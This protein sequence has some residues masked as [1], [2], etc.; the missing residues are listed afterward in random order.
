M[1]SCVCFV[2]IPQAATV[3]LLCLLRHS[4]Y[5][6]Q[7]QCWVS[8]TVRQCWRDPE[9]KFKPHVSTKCLSTK[10]W[11]FRWKRERER[12]TSEKERMEFGGGDKLSML[13]Q[14]RWMYIRL[15]SP[16]LMLSVSVE[17]RTAQHYNTSARAHASSPLP[18]FPLSLFPSFTNSFPC[19]PPFIGRARSQLWPHS[20]HCTKTDSERENRTNIWIPVNKNDVHSISYHSPSPYLSLTP[21][22]P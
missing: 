6:S 13:M 22:R 10:V 1:Y 16:Q 18:F 14:T 15:T 2:V 8:S 21:P 17:G 19:Y 12:K 11:P 7:M 4:P 5:P 20:S 3:L 9:L